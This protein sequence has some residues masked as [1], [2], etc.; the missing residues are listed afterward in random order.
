MDKTPSPAVKEA[1]KPYRMPRP[2]SI[3]MWRSAPG[4]DTLPAAVT[5]VGKTSL[6][7]M[8]FPPDSRGA[9]PKD[10]VRH[11]TDPSLATMLDQDVGVWEHTPEFTLMLGV[12]EVLRLLVP[13]LGE[14][15]ELKKTIRLYL[16]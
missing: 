16:P 9:M 2:G 10:G 4:G 11:A 7:L 14:D 6:N 13:D 12:F 5:R 8:V 15:L 3:V 1:P